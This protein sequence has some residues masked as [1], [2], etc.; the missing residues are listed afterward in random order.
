MKKLFILLTTLSLLFIS[1]TF[2][3]A[4]ADGIKNLSKSAILLEA[5]TGTVICK[6]NEKAR[7]P[8]ASMTKIML[9]NLCF[10]NIEQGNLSLDEDITVSKN[11]SGM[12]G[13]QVFL[14]ANSKY[15]AKDLIKSVII[16]S[17]NDASVA[18]AERLYGSET[19]CVSV[20]NAKCV[21][22]KLDNTLFSNC[23][24][25][26]KPTQYSS[27]EDVAIMLKHLI[28]HKD[29]FSYS[30]IWMDEIKHSGDRVTGLTNTNK[31][32][33]FYDGC[34]GGKTGY[35]SE[36][37][38]CLA[39]TAKRGGLRLISVVINSPDSKSRFN[40]VSNMFNYGF[41]NY[42][43]KMVIDSSKPLEIDVKIGK[44][45]NDKIEI[46]PINDVFV[47]SKRNEKEKIT[48]DFNPIEKCA[49]V[50]KGEKVGELI[51]F[52]SGVE[53]KRVD[54]VTTCDV[55]VKTY[56]DY[57]KDIAKNWSL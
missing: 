41:D 49:P 16:A 32:V 46:K 47:F 54:V 50:S 2:I 31:L 43:S 18:L 4:N 3:S 37:G 19:E 1:T 23:T 5:E 22:W 45:K 27:A 57:I 35:T 12:G 56:F 42:T 28:S 15:K 6:S 21:E 26:P 36:S 20:M 34:D 29:Y 14:E 10:E 44:S 13:S 30:N 33:K 38:F 55:Q 24:G 40:E 11:A 51:V 52:R 39:A 17:A 7:L 9:L 8:I 25:L 48:I 53:Y